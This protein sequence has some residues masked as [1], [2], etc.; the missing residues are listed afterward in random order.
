MNQ[1]IQTEEAVQLAP[2]LRPGKETSEHRLSLI[3]AIVTATIGAI[4]PIFVSSG[5]ITADLSEALILLI[6]AVSVVLALAVPGWIVTNYTRQRTDL[7]KTIAANH[8]QI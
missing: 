6:D 4:L 3:F 1:N 5:T 7:K 2:I 8:R